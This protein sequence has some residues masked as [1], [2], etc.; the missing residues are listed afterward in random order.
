MELSIVGFNLPGRRFCR[1]D[2]TPMNDVHVAVQIRHDPADPIPADAAEAQWSVEIDVVEGGDALD[3]RGPAVQGKRG[4][5]FVYLT[6][7][8]VAGDEF[9]MF[10]RAKLMLGR[11]DERVL[12]QAV[13]SGHLVARVDLTGDGGGPRCARVDPPAIEWSAGDAP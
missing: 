4:D 11:I 9:E 6:W 5:R 1:P 12:R 7:G 3:F 2:G 8:D 10:R 13:A